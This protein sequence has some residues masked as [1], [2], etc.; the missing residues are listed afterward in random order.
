MTTRGTGGQ[1]DEIA[2]DAVAQGVM[3]DLAHALVMVG[4]HP[5]DVK[6]Q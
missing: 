2:E 4:R 1:V 6:D 3:G 5:D